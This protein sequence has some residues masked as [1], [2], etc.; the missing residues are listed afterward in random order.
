M[1]VLV[2]MCGVLGGG[3][4]AFAW[5]PDGHQAAAMI[6]EARLTPEAKAQVAE[7]LEGKALSDHAVVIWADVLAPKTTKPWHYVDIPFKETSYVP[8]RDGHGGDN[9]IEKTAELA[10]VL[11]DRSKPVEERQRALKYLI[12][13]VGDMHQPLHAVERVND[14]GKPDKGGNLV[15]VKVPGRDLPIALHLAWDVDLVKGA[16][17]EKSVQVFAQELGK[18]ITDEQ[19]KAWT[20]GVAGADGNVPREV[21]IGW[22]L[23]SHK[24]GVENVYPGIPTDGSVVTLDAGYLEKNQKVVKEQITKAGVRLAAVLNEEFK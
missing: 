16:M 22:V 23:E 10:R 3:S 24:L 14:D 8:E 7:L 21:V 15:K 4:C 12:H 2:L 11:K 20:A 5:G 13:F 17:G 1:N 18:T 6:A 9:V 19:A